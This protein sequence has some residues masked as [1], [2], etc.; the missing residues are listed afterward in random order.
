MWP[1]AIAT[2][3]RNVSPVKTER[4]SPPLSTRSGG[5]SPRAMAT[6]RLRTVDRP[7][8]STH[9]EGHNRLRRMEPIFGLV[10]DNRLRAVNHRVRDLVASVGGQAVHVDGVRLRQTHAPLVADPVL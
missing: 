4:T 3:A 6:Q 7:A 10:I 9:G 2:F 8:L 1:S 5:S